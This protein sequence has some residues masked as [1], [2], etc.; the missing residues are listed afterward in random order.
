MA[1]NVPDRPEPTGSQPPQR[2]G[3]ASWQYVFLSIV[4]AIVVVFIIFPGAALGVFYPP[5]DYNGPQVAGPLA[6]SAAPTQTPGGPTAT[7]EPPTAPPTVTPSVVGTLSATP[8]VNAAATAEATR[9]LGTSITG[10]RQDSAMYSQYTHCLA[11]FNGFIAYTVKFLAIGAAVVTTICS[12]QG[13]RAFGFI[14]G[15]LVTA[16]T[17]FQTQFPM[18]A[19]ATF[20]ASI[21]NQTDAI[22]TQ[23]SYSVLDDQKLSD[24]R[25]AFNQIKET[26]AA[27]PLMPIAATPSVMPSVTTTATATTT[28]A[29]VPTIAP[30]G[31]SSAV[32]VSPAPVP[33]PSATPS[34]PAAASAIPP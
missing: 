26:A 16:L 10:L 23:V 30:G 8:T 11:R 34:P 7:P 31:S 20:F 21:A 18:D 29:V 9:I 2:P 5:C 6:L 24:L 14:A 27:G 32:A 1:T 25:S 15:A 19:R 22:V 17:A 33:S 3:A 4:I 13:W 12:T 28:P